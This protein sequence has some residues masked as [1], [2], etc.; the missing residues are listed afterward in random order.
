MIELIIQKIIRKYIM[1]PEE[2]AS[3]EFKWI[4]E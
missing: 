2:N 4:D 1:M 3:Q